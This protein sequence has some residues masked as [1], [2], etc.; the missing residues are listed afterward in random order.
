M[1]NAG[2]RLAIVETVVT[3]MQSKQSEIYNDVKVI[4]SHVAVAQEKEKQRL[5]DDRKTVIKSAACGT[6]GGGIIAAILEF[7]TRQ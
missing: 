6:G 1:A 3:G 4:L 5:R 2:E 7:L